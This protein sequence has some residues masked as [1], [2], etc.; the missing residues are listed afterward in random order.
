[1]FLPVIFVSL[2]VFR[3]T[4]CEEEESDEDFALVRRDSHQRKEL[5]TYEIMKLG[6]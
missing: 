2:L 5:V 1:M 4:F 3:G 6:F